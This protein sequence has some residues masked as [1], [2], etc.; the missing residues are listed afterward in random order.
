MSQKSSTNKNINNSSVEGFDTGSDALNKVGD[1]LA[2]SITTMRDDIILFAKWS[3]INVFV[4]W[5]IWRVGAHV[6]WYNSIPRILLKATYP[7]GYDYLKQILNEN[8]GDGKCA[9]VMHSGGMVQEK[10]VYEP[11]QLELFNEKKSCCPGLELPIPEGDDMDVPCWPLHT[12][13]STVKKLNDQNFLYKVWNDDYTQ[14]VSYV[15]WKGEADQQ[16][17]QAEAQS[18]QA[19]IQLE[20]ARQKEG[21]VGGEFTSWFGNSPGKF[22]GRNTKLSTLGSADMIN[23]AS[24]RRSGITN[25]FNRSNGERLSDSVINYRIE[26]ARAAAQD[27]SG[28]RWK[29]LTGLTRADA[30]R[31][32]DFSNEEAGIKSTN[33]ELKRRHLRSERR[34]DQLIRKAQDAVAGSFGSDKIDVK[35]LMQG[36]QGRDVEQEAAAATGATAPIMNMAAQPA[37][38]MQKRLENVRRIAQEKGIDAALESD[39]FKKLSTLEQQQEVEQMMKSAAAVNKTAEADRLKRK[40]ELLKKEMKIKETDQSKAA[41]LSKKEMQDQDNLSVKH[42]KR[43][44]MLQMTLDQKQKDDMTKR[45]A[46]LIAKKEQN[47]EKQEKFN[48]KM[49][50]ATKR[51]DAVLAKKLLK[52]RE[53]DVLEMEKAENTLTAAAGKGNMEAA[54]GVAKEVIEMIWKGIL[55]LLKSGWNLL[56]FLLKATAGCSWDQGLKGIITGPNTLTSLSTSFILAIK[57]SVSWLIYSCITASGGNI[58]I[59]FLFATIFLALGTAL[60][61]IVWISPLSTLWTFFEFKWPQPIMFAGV[62]LFIPLAAIYGIIFGIL[63]I[64]YSWAHVLEFHFNCLFSSKGDKFKSQLKGCSNIQA[65]LRRIFFILTIINAVQTLDPKVVTGII[66]CFLYIEYKKMK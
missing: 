55:W 4:V 65:T 14:C 44:A 43:L 11:D 23:E 31:N 58:I 66:L 57:A 48:T 6:I 52:E 50:D 54:G 42:T 49:A 56:I 35:E 33:A 22:S 21:Q 45:L 62:I 32:F 3:V 18:I 17:A 51:K 15:T 20:K 5:V 13:H 60:V 9:D 64:F 59:S 7:P 30:M 46:K 28:A 40:L 41:Q 24:L 16:A 10:A 25:M 63:Y 27:H 47:R 53:K 61:N 2:E 29:E 34:T 39:H 37:G 19:E 1:E 8:M 12:S 26:Q 38:M 36:Q